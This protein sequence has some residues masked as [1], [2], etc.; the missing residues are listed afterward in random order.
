MERKMMT[1]EDVVKKVIA[2]LGVVKIPAELIDEIGIPVA[3]AIRNL[4]MCVEA[5]AREAENAE[6]AELFPADPKEDDGK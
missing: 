4:K 6:P 2:E 1:V 5:W 3:Q